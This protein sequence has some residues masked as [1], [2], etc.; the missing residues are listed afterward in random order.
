MPGFALR[1]FEVVKIIRFLLL[2]IIII[3]V[4][5]ITSSSSSIFLLAL[6]GLS[7]SKCWFGR[8]TCF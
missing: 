5:I 1:Y 3:V 6:Q 4:I 7:K 8:L 2:L